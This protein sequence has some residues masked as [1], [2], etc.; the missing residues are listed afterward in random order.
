MAAP[1]SP[2]TWSIEQLRFPKALD[3][4]PRAAALHARLRAS[5]RKLWEGGVLEVPAL[6]WSASLATALASAQA[7]GQ[8]IQG[9]EQAERALARE[10][11]GLAIAD[12]RSAT[13]RGSRVSRLLLTS[14]DGAERFYRQIE[15]L[16]RT[17]GARLLALRL[18]VDSAR[19]SSVLGVPDG[20]TRAL[21]V[22][23]KLGVARVLA[24]LSDGAAAGP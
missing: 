6:P 17:Q 7:E 19:L 20:V 18:D 11:R 5:C 16:L 14:N 12:A 24:S 21:L 1:A 8:L 3:D 9:I 22:E 4:D 2:A 23:H 10:A 13:E 15:R